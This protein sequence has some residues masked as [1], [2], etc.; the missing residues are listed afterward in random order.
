VTVA[1]LSPRPSSVAGG[2]SCAK[3]Q[4]NSKLGDEFGIGALLPRAAGP[5]SVRLPV[6]DVRHQMTPIS[7][8]TPI[9]YAPPLQISGSFGGGKSS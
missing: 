6:T 1:A 3:E 7:T 9:Q 8:R 2:V 5:I 4:R